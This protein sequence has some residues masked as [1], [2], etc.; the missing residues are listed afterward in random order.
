MHDQSNESDATIQ[1]KRNRLSAS[2]TELLLPSG[3]ID[4]L[5]EEVGHEYRERIYT[6]SIVVWMFIMQVLSKDHS[7]QQVVARFNGWRIAQGLRRVSSDTT[8]YCKAR[9]RLPEKL[10]E[11]LLALTAARCEEAI[12]QALLFHGRQVIMVDGWTVTMADTSDNQQAYP[13]L[14]SQKRGCGFPIARMVGLFSLATGAIERFAIAPYAGKQTGETSLLRL[15]WT[16]VLPGQIVLADRYYATYWL[17]ASSEKQGID[18][19]AR[20]HHLRTVDFRRGMKLGRFDQLV[21]YQRPKQRPQWM[22]TEEYATYPETILVRHLRYRHTQKG[23]RTHELTLATTLDR[24]KYSVEDLAELYRRRWEV[25][26]N[27]RSLKTQMQM[28]HLRCKRPSMVRKEIACH[29]IAYNLVRAT[30]VVSA[31]TTGMP[32]HHIS[33]TGTMQ[34][35]E[36]FAT[37]LRYLK[38]DKQRR[39]QQLL[40]SIA[41][42]QVGHRPGRVEPR[43]LKRRPKPYKW[44]TTPRKSTRNPAATAA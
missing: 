17:L 4:R 22:S 26:L 44:M 3:L 7:C 34:S 25:E 6:P 13:Q 14:K 15:I 43:E 39:W 9:I 35:L 37:S 29:M 12:D 38:R 20:V 16:R 33:F 24:S 2:V 5:C 36:E 41:E 23:F 40:Q 10:F 19:V 30:M 27:I 32:P 8:S 31:L 11:R 28:E 18:F 1:I 42:I 21:V